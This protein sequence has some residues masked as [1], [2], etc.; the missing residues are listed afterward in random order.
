M[1]M[2][3]SMQAACIVGAVRSGCQRLC[4][5]TLSLYVLCRDGAAEEAEADGV[6]GE[7]HMPMAPM[8]SARM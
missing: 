5:A 4:T 2:S 3:T 6:A 7:Q 1:N 8:A